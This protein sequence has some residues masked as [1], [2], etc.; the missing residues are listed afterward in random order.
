MSGSVSSAHVTVGLVGGL[1]SVPLILERAQAQALIL[2]GGLALLHTRG[3]ARHKISED[4]EFVVSEAKGRVVRRAPTASAPP[5][6]PHLGAV[7]R[8]L[9][10]Q[11][12]K[13][14]R[15]PQRDGAPHRGG[16]DRRG[17]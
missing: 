17:Q 2:D 6:R 11:A 10:A 16:A 1:P 5:I 7:L 8:S 13:Q 3:E 4:A 9:H 15:R 12:V 14:V